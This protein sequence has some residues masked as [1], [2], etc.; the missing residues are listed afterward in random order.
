MTDSEFYTSKEDILKE[1]SIRKANKAQVIE[2]TNNFIYNKYGISNFIG[3]FYDFLGNKN[4]NIASNIFIGRAIPSFTIEELYINSFAKK[5]NL[6]QKALPLLLD[7]FV[8]SS[9][10][11][12]SRLILSLLNNQNKYSLISNLQKINH[13]P[14]SNIITDSG[15]Y[16]FKWHLERRSKLFGEEN[17][18]G[19]DY[20]FFL[21][22][23]VLLSNNKP[24]YIYVYDKKRSK[25]TKKNYSE[26]VVKSEDSFRPC[27]S[28]FYPIYFCFFT[29]DNVL[30]EDYSNVLY[31]KD[32]PFSQMVLNSFKEVESSIGLKPLILKEQFKDEIAFAYIEDSIFNFDTFVHEYDLFLKRILE[33]NEELNEVIFLDNLKRH[34][35]IQDIVF[36]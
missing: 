22:D 5:Y 10:D 17:N 16:L 23:L 29:L 28:W 36:V 27:A 13:K 4:G 34:F 32:E 31:N 1:F 2:K 12:H 24:E 30:Y 7:S 11:K 3:R 20:S 15:E 9:K 21:R 14:I 18:N 8:L 33:T 26:T 25:M 6:R 35:N 19:V